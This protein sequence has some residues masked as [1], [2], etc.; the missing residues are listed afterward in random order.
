MLDEPEED[1]VEAG[2]LLRAG[3]SLSVPCAGLPATFSS[4]AA[5]LGFLNDGVAPRAS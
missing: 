4:L 5:L 1:L 2:S 3:E